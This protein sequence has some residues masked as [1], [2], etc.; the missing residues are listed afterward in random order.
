MACK[1]LSF[2]SV[3]SVKQGKYLKCL[4]GFDSHRSLYCFDSQVSHVTPSTIV[5]LEHAPNDYHT[6]VAKKSK[7]TKLVACFRN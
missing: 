7:E 3:W 1:L 2:L 6:N 4:Q 5:V